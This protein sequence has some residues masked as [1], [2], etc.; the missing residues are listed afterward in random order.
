MT[1]PA[2]SQSMAMGGMGVRAQGMDGRKK[3]T[4][5]NWLGLS[6]DNTA[7]WAIDGAVDG[8]GNLFLSGES[9]AS[10]DLLVARYAPDGQRSWSVEVAS[11][12]PGGFLTAGNIGAA[13]IALDAS[14]NVHA[15]SGNG[16]TTC[17]TRKYSSGGQ[18]LWGRTYTAGTNT[19]GRAVAV[20]ASGSVYV[21]MRT[22]GGGFG[23]STALVVKYNAAGAFQWSQ[24]VDTTVGYGLAL[25]ASENVYV[26]YNTLFKLNS[27]GSLQWA[28]QNTAGTITTVNR[29]VA[30]A[31]GNTYTA[32][33]DFAGIA[34]LFAFDASGGVAWAR[35]LGTTGTWWNDVLLSGQSLYCIGVTTQAGAGSND[36]LLAE[37]DTSGTLK[38]QRTIGGAGADYGF[39]IAEAD[40]NTLAIFGRTSLGAGSGDVFIGRVPKSGPPAG[41]IGPYTVTVS[42]L[43]ASTISSTYSAFSPS[44]QTLG[45]DAASALT[46]SAVSLTTSI[47]PF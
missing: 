8:Q 38:W 12:G 7:N 27:A 14:G 6:G 32:G 19:F 4:A 35:T 44:T 42:N 40:A 1:L 23:G 13:A 34:Q 17:E 41:R 31:A 24:N 37:Y 3:G 25:D 15:V 10:Q 9:G 26:G 18:L 16:S 2:G 46:D 36:I 5:S 29:M 33:F 11:T 47:Y 30:N 20:G 22:D 21:L 39:A 45:S 28:T 43:T